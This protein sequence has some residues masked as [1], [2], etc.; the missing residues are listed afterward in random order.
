MGASL[1]DAAVLNYKNEVGVSN[2][3]QAVCDHD[4]GPAFEECCQRLLD[5]RL[6]ARVDVARG[7][8]QY[9]DARVRQDRPGE[10]EELAL[11][12]AERSS[13]LAQHGIVAVRQIHDEAVGVDH[14]GRRFDLPA[15]RLSGVARTAVADVLGDGAGEQ[16]GFLQ[17]DPYVRPQVLAG[18]LPDVPSVYADRTFGGVVEAGDEACDGRLARARRADKGDR[19]AWLDHEVHV[20]QHGPSRIVFER[21]VL[22]GDEAPGRAELRGV[23]W[24]R[25]LRFFVQNVVDA[26]CAGDR[27]LGLG[28]YLGGELNGT[29]EL[30]DVDQEGR[31]HADRERAGED[32]VPAVADD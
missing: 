24:I 6:R 8:I 5:D 14:A 25:G 4:A 16:E 12:L 27:G 3:A 22:E 9:E 18:H 1:L 31:Q 17:H 26:F 20:V 11:A 13:A 21:H 19:L 29:E 2:G 23:R 32:Q 10:R 15:A 7:L 28:V 30:L